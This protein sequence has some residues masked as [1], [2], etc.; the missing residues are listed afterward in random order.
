MNIRNCF[1][2]LIVSLLLFV[3]SITAGAVTYSQMVA[4][5]NGNPISAEDFNWAMNRLHRVMAAQGGQLT[6]DNVGK[7]Q[8]LT[9]QGLLKNELLFLESEALGIKIDSALVDSEYEKLKAQ[10]STEQQFVDAMDQLNVSEGT[11]RRQIMRGIAAKQ[12]LVNVFIPEVRFEK[13]TS[14]NITRSIRMNLFNRSWSASDTS[15]LR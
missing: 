12:M 13:M 6:E 9:L 11:I 8:Q 2:L 4:S 1:S 7:V 15:C 5:V 3:G 10:F 14:K